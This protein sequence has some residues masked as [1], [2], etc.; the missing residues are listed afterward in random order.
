MTRR[1]RDRGRK[2]DGILLLDK[3]AG[4]TSNAALQHVKRAFGA[5]K[6][7][8][9][10]SLDPIAT[11]LLPVCFGEATKLSGFFL[12]ADK[13]YRAGFRLGVAT[14]TGDSEGGVVRRSTVEVGDEDIERAMDR[15]RGNFEQ[16][17]SM[18]SAIKKNGKPLYEL[19][20]QGIEV[21]RQARP[22]TVHALD[23]ERLEDDRLAVDLHC[24]SG[25]YV[26]SLAHDLGEALG[27]GAHVDALTR[28]AVGDF[29]LEDA[30]SLDRVE[31][32]REDIASLDELLIPG[33][34][35]LQHLPGIT[36]STDAA[37]YLVRGQAVRAAKLPR[38]GLVRLYAEEAGFLGVGKVLGDGRV[39]PK[40]L[41]QSA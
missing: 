23:W 27:C 35:G 6:A 15:F 2:V 36:L 12:S 17:P 19:A 31:A 33:D 32:L 38:S 4:L 3:P 26:R 20:R 8:H 40:R 1:N 10:G 11:G 28:V 14:E 29:K 22:V 25:F 16:I 13:R 5:S 21:E 37:Y 34:R 18:Y 41:F 7:G 24:S 9:T 30:V 39:A